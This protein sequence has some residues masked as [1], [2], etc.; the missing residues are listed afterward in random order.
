[1][2]KLDLEERVKNGKWEKTVNTKG[3]LKGHM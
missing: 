3:L 1:M 2:E